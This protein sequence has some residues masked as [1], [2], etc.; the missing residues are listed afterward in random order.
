MLV[1]LLLQLGPLGEQCLELRVEMLLVLLFYLQVRVLGLYQVLDFFLLLVEVSFLSLVLLEYLLDL[2]SFRA[3]D[4]LELALLE[5]LLGI[6][7]LQ[8]LADPLAGEAI[9]PAVVDSDIF[10]PVAGQEIQIAVAIDIR[11]VA[12]LMSASCIC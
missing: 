6:V 5:G 2:A 10:A 7:A 4:V 1:V 8:D 11:Q 12:Q 3:K 9:W